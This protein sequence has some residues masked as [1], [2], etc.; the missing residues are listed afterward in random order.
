MLQ[1]TLFRTDSEL[2]V[3]NDADRVGSLVQFPINPGWQ[4]EQIS[5]N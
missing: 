3:R 4:L 2:K 5:Q 1:N